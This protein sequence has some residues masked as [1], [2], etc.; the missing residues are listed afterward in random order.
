MSGIMEY[1]IVG[2]FWKV[3]LLQVTYV[4]LNVVTEGGRQ[5]ISAVHNG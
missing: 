1:P 5:V 4:T 2:I 3:V